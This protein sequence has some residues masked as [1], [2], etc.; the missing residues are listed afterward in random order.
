MT[1]FFRCN[2]GDEFYESIRAQLDAAWGLPDAQTKTVT[3]IDPATVAVRDAEG[4]ILLAVW[5]EFCEFTVAVDLLPELLASGA[6]TEIDEPTYMA[7][8]PSPY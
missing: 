1:R 4:R 2:A 6:I 8:K 7:A 5:A 3:C